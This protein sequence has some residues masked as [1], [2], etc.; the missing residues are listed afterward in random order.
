MSHGFSTFNAIP[1]AKRVHSLDG[2][3]G[4]AAL[5]VVVNHVMVTGVTYANV[6]DGRG[7][8]DQLSFDWWWSY[9]PLHL[10]WGGTEAV[11]VFFIL[12]GYVLSGP[13]QKSTFSWFA[14]YPK[15]II[16]LYLPVW[17]SL[18]LAGLTTLVITR[19]PKDGASW[20]TN[21]HGQVDIVSAARSG[22][23]LDKIDFLNN[24]L[25]SL[26]WELWFSLLLPVY[27]IACKWAAAS[28]T[29]TGVLVAVL[30]IVMAG[31]S[32]V[33][34]NALRYLPMFA[35]GILLYLHRERA[36]AV[37]DKFTEMR[38]GW[39][40]VALTAVLLTTSYW[41]AQSSPSIPAAVASFCRA[42]QVG[43][44]LLF[45]FIALYCGPARRFLATPPLA[46]LGLISFSLY[47][48][49]D[50]V[51]ISW[52]MLMGGS[53]SPWLTLS[54]VLPISLA[55]GGLFYLAVEKPSKT[56]SESAGAWA[57]A[58]ATTRL[59]VR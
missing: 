7:R 10:L 30:G 31:G 9:T 39:S 25:W 47:L 17:G 2:L 45:V 23:L 6:A 41:M 5:I 55:F 22:L 44:A 34:S 42:L 40:L 32:V 29:R 15:R 3:R 50:A 59:T 1:T 11:F 12:S 4:V 53:P 14:Y 37:G 18:V 54:I 20:W 57:S 49:H 43:G 24:P 51:V 27:T 8:A 16:R 46:W 13:T 38:G 21:S 28:L 52:T 35:F 36:R 56:L 48:T 33:G 19:E 58:K 26:A